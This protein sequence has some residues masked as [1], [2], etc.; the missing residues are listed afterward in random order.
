ML[1]T[2]NGGTTSLEPVCYP[3]KWSCC[4]AVCHH[5]RY[6]SPQCPLRRLSTGPNAIYHFGILGSRGGKPGTPPTVEG[7]M[8]E[9]GCV[10]TPHVAA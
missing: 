3:G 7:M 9:L 5:D 1:A 2:S 4:G 6:A 10:G 8:D